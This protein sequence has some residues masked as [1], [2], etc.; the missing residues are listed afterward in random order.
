MSDHIKEVDH[1]PLLGQAA[2]AQPNTAQVDAEVTVS[3]K[4]R[5]QSVS[6]DDHRKDEDGLVLIRLECASS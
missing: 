5:G 1:V 2:P 3:A 4:H 6:G